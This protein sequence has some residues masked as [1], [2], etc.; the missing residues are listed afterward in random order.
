MDDGSAVNDE[1]PMNTAFFGQMTPDTGVDQLASLNSIR[2]SFQ[3]ARV[4]SSTTPPFRSSVHF[5]QVLEHC[6]P[7]WAIWYLISGESIPGLSS[8]PNQIVSPNPQHQR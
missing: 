3:S 6:Q 7:Q 5:G 4:E 8:D 2:G 1:L